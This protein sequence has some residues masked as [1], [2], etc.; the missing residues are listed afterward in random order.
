MKKG[1]LVKYMKTRHPL[2]KD[3]S[4]LYGVGSVLRTF[5]NRPFKGNHRACVHWS[6]GR[7]LNHPI[8][9]L[10]VINESR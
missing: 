2:R 9:F 6:H 10:R 1:T 3:K 4:E 8:S 5:G 7:V